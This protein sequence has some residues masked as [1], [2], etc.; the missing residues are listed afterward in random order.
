M[1]LPMSD[2]GTFISKG[3]ILVASLIDLGGIAESKAS[4]RT[5]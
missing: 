5:R 1:R 3:T 4:V 2:L